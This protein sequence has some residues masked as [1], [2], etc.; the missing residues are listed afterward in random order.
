M[1][2]VLFTLAAVA[3][4][5]ACNKVEVI[6]TAPKTPISFASSFVDNTTKAAIDKSYGGE[7]GQTALTQFNVYG[8]VT[9]SANNPVNIFDGSSV[10]GNIGNAVWACDNIQYW[11]TGAK[12]DFT[13]IAGVANAAGVA[14]NVSVDA[15]GMP[16]S[17]SYSAENQNDVLFVK[18]NQYT[19]LENNEPVAF[20]FNHILSKVKFT[21]NNTTPATDGNINYQY[22]V[23]DIQIL[24]AAKTGTFTVANYVDT[25]NNTNPWS[26]TDRYS[27]NGTDYVSFGNATKSDSENADASYI[28]IGDEDDNGVESNYERLVIPATYTALNVKFTV[29]LYK[30]FSD[31]DYQI[32]NRDTYTKSIGVTF[33]PGYAYNFVINVGLNKTIEFKVVTQP[34]WTSASGDVTVQ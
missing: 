20:T 26:V 31:T 3:A 6:E 24:N 7:T 14:Q 16:T 30:K 27:G 19:A 8:T 28:I 2:K 29:E 4:L 32:I 23:K 18:N 12:Y 33:V 17:I 22:M 34:G 11:I 1:K 21:V 25:D 13:A 10:E 15:T 5:A 9:G